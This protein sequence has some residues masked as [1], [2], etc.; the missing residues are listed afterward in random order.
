MSSLIDLPS[1]DP[2]EPSMLYGMANAKCEHV[3]AVPDISIGMA[4]GADGTVG[5]QVHI[6]DSAG[7]DVRVETT[8]GPSGAGFEIGDNS[9]H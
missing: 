4:V 9:N 5:T 6:E 3:C 1:D 8:A 7:T 2:M